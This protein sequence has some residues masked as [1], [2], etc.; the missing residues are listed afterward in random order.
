MTLQEEDSVCASINS[1][2]SGTFPFTYNNKVIGSGIHS[3]QE[4]ASNDYNPKYSIY[5]MIG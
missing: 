1:P 3:D 4:N 5:I 2:T